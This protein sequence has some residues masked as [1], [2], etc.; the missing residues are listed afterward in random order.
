[1]RRR[2][3]CSADSGCAASRL[4]PVSPAH[5]GATLPR[6]R[7][8]VASVRRHRPS[9]LLGDGCGMASHGRRHPYRHPAGAGSG[10][11]GDR[12][13]H[14]G[15]NFQR[16]G[17]HSAQD[18]AGHSPY[19]VLACVAATRISNWQG[20]HQGRGVRGRRK[21]G[22]PDAPP[23]RSIQGRLCVKCVARSASALWV[24]WVPGFPKS[25][26]E[27]DCFRQSAPSAGTAVASSAL[28]RHTLAGP[29]RAGPDAFPS[30]VRRPALSAQ[31]PG[32]RAH[33]RTAP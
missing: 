10:K 13:L 18:P 5:L 16:W 14:S 4:I 21:H 32:R 24:R 31:G 30:S 2:P 15:S 11:R 22:Q 19:A 20:G 8:P 25:L 28:T 29:E 23:L 33:L 27:S 12:R 17:A 26:R 1:M 7:Q 9:T 6:I 3:G